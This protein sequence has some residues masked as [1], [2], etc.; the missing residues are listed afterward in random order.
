VEIIEKLIHSAQTITPELSNFVIYSKQALVGGSSTISL[1]EGI[2][3][4]L[5]TKNLVK[6]VTQDWP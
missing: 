6:S 5:C 2:I 4:A 3:K 1:L